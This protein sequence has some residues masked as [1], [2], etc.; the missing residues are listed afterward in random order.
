MACH[1][2]G[3]AG[4]SEIQAHDLMTLKPT[5]AW[6]GVYEGV[7]GELRGMGLKV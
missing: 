7:K 3:A 4:W 1:S 5:A 2:G 6:V